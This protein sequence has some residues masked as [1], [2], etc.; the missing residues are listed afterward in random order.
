MSMLV[1]HPSTSIR[2]D[3]ALDMLVG[4]K[5]LAGMLVFVDCTMFV[6]V[7]K[8]V[9]VMVDVAITGVADAFVTPMIT[10]VGE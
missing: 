5:V 3:G 8:K 7:G 9:G 10:G 6:P 1:L 4:V 2:S